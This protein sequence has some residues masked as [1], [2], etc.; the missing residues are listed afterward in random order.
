MIY[1]MLFLFIFGSVIGSFLGCMGY[2]IP[3]KIK[4]TYPPSFCPECKKRLKWYMNIPIFSYIFLKGKCKYCKKPIGFIYFFTELLCAILFVLSYVLYGF[5]MN[6][7]LSIILISALIVT[8]ISDFLY[9]YISDRVLI[10]STI[11][12]IIVLY[13]F[14]V[15][16]TSVLKS[17]MSGAIMFGVMYAIKLFGNYIFKKESLGDGDIKLMGVIAIALG[18]MNSFFA[19]FLAA[20]IGLIYSFFISRINKD[21]IIP[22]GPFLLISALITIY[23]GDFFL[24]IISSIL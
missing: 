14:N 21:G 15:D 9:Y 18:I 24:K 2:R 4:T 8:L 23:F 7:F 13:I 10:I 1:I 5:D 6:F 20:V 3:N 17:I 19:L 16:K 22:F 12:I 11:L